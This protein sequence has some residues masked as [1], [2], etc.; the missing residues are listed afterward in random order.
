M[1]IEYDPS[2][3]DILRDP[4]HVF[5]EL[6]AEDPVHW[7]E[8]LA[9]WIITEYKLSEQALNAKE[10]LSADRLRPFTE[11]LQGSARATLAEVMRWLS[12]WATFQDPP[13]HTRLRKHMQRVMNA[14]VV[15]EMRPA[16][17][18]VTDELLDAM[19][20]GESF[21]F[22]ED[23]ALIL[24]GYVV[25]D[26]IGVPRERLAEVK[27][28]SDDMMLFIGS[29]RGVSEKYERA[30][31]GA[32]EMAGLFR[33]LV[34]DRRREPQDD[35]LTALIE[36]DMDGDRLDDDEVIGCMMMLGNGAQGTTAHLLA[37]SMMIFAEQPNLVARLKGE[38]QRLPAAIEEFLRFDGPVLSIS[39]I[40][41]RDVE[42]G[43]KQLK[44]GDRLFAMLTAANRDPKVFVEPDS[45]DI[46][47]T[48]NR[49]LA[50]S[51]GTHF[52]LGAPLARLE[53]D[54]AL[55]AIL[56]RVDRVTITEPVEQIPWSNSLVTRGPTRLNL[57][58]S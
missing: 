4:H 5:A 11:R 14:R 10:A 29:S 25:L 2:N 37:R 48:P 35:A 30:R 39:R 19:P 34:E 26:M 49:H 24:P 40:V 33:E 56:S 27:S 21:D 15:R 1:S 7:C 6:R 41:S 22:H 3:P 50:F 51:M 23:F 18:A 47:R 16:I 54:V 46:E 53:A 12:L 43:G 52:C 58:W 13:D 9:G 36:S 55:S 57:S 31:R 17:E 20:T 8:P 32:Q 38:P 45:I 28:W 44:E 42:L